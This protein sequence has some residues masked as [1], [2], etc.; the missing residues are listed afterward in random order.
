VSKGENSMEPAVLCE[1][2]GGDDVL[3]SVQYYD[4]LGRSVQTRTEAPAN[5]GGWPWIVSHTAHD[6]QGRA[7]WSYVPFYT[8]AAS[9]QPV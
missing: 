1:H 6:A 4:G 7:A 5:A 3:E 2:S 9:R 8:D